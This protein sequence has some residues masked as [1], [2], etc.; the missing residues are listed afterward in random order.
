MQPINIVPVVFQCV[1]LIASLIG[2][3]TVTAD[4]DWPQFR[5]PAAIGVAPEKSNPPTQWDLEQDL[6]WVTDIPGVG[7]S[8]PVFSDGVIWLTSAITREATPEELEAR[9][10]RS[11][12][13]AAVTVLKTA[14]GSVELRAICVDLESGQL[15]HDLSLKTVDEPELINPMNSYASPTPAM[16]DGKVICHFGSNGTWCLD[17]KSGEILWQTGFVVNHSVGAGSSPIVFEGTVMLVCD[18][19]DDQFVVGVDLTNGK[20][21]WRTDRPPMRNADGERQKA[22]CTP[23][24]IE[25][26]GKTQAVIPTAQWIVAYDPTN[27]KE[28]WRADHGSGFSV[29]PMA[30][31]QSGLVIFSTGFMKPQFVAV[32]PRGTGDV[33]ETHLKWRARNAPSMASVI[34]DGGRLYSILDK[35][36][37]ICLDAESGEELERKRIGGNYSASPLLAAGNLY[38]GSREGLM[39]IVHCSAGLETVATHQ[40]D[41]SLMASP[42][43]IG[44]DLIIRSEK[45]LYRIRQ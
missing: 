32:D 29:T 22:Y 41:S 9:R 4:N 30:A 8:S 43:V 42:A 17:A 16:A 21:I 34:V 31:Y 35:G 40:F 37:L 3:A 19:T 44:D 39:T 28:I 10:Q 33:T 6:A 24:L 13:D 38:L 27:G 11:D 45:K 36:V 18:G 15:L 26:E 5:G 1:G 20:Q 14:A 2:S 25:V 23:L 7:W 12:A